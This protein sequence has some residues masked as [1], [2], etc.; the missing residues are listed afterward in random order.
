M[1]FRNGK[2]LTDPGPDDRYQ[3]IISSGRASVSNPIVSYFSEYRALKTV[4]KEFWLVNTLSFFDGLA[5]FSMMN[6][7]TLYLT[8]NCGFSDVDSSALIGLYTLAI[9]IIFFAVGAVCDTLGIKKSFLFGLSLLIIARLTF[10]FA[11]M[12]LSNTPIDL[13][14]PFIPELSPIQWSVVFMMAMMALGTSFMGPVMTTSLRRFTA[15]ENR[16]IGFSM[17]YLIMNIGAILAGFAVTDGLRSLFGEQNGNLAI[18]FFGMGANIASFIAMMMVNEHRY[19]DES[20]RISPDAET[21][22][23]LAIFLEVWKESAFR[24]LVIFLVLTIGVRLVFTHQFM[25]MPKYYTR[26]LQGDFELGLANSINPTI[27]VAG[28]I[29]LI[30]LFSKISTFKLV[31]IGM[32]I[33]ASSLLIMAVPIEWILTLPYVHNLDQ[34][35]LFIIVAQILV[36]AFGELLFSPRFTEYISLMAPKDKVASYMSLSALPTFISK[37]VN[38]FISGLLIATF[39]Y[40]GIRAKIDAGLIDYAHSPEFMWMVYFLLAV[41][42]PIAVLFMRN[43]LTRKPEAEIEEP[44]TASSTA[45]D[46][47]T[48]AV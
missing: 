10:G 29:L 35:Y 41:I 24:K 21:K 1:V 18:M 12:Y 9:S 2:G 32:A 13:P 6:V 7:L 48:E 11:P 5:Y 30:P 36:F 46:T 42:S 4:S 8:A 20:E 45:T 37:P 23:P 34:A 14:I 43:F 15:K 25:V 19:A 38:G 22:R 17:Y 47:A 26:V 44:I 28:L 27:I 31:V 40:D 16:S 3:Q 33:S 39:S